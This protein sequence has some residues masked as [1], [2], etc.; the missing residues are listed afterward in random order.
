MK[1]ILNADGS[2]NLCACLVQATKEKAGIRKE[3]TSLNSSHTHT[4]RGKYLR[5]FNVNSVNKRENAS[6]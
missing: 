3:T 6:V 1:M 2:T 5:I 4:F